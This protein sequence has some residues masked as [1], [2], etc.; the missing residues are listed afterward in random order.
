[1]QEIALSLEKNIYLETQNQ[2]DPNSYKET[3]KKIV[4][5]LKN[6]T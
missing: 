1:M 3:S 2:S 5:S 6:N 4:I